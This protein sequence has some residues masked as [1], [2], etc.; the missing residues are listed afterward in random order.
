MYKI[1]EKRK[2]KSAFTFMLSCFSD[3]VLTKLKF[4]QSHNPINLSIPDDSIIE[5]QVRQTRVSKRLLDLYILRH[6][7]LKLKVELYHKSGLH[8]GPVHPIS[9]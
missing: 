1:L 5:I 9:H 4:S 7:M 8:L 6:T 3:F 2:E